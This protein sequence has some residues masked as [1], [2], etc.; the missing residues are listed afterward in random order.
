MRITLSLICL[1][2][3]PCASAAQTNN[4][5]WTNLN[6]LQAGEK[7]QVVDINAKKH[8]GIFTSVSDSAISINTSKGQESVQKDEVRTV[9]LAKG[10]HRLRNSLIG[11]G[12]GAG[13]GAGIGAASGD[14]KSSPLEITR[15][16]KAA[17]GSALGGL[18]GTLAGLLV[19]SGGSSAIYSASPK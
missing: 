19:P 14:S 11:L 6:G 3:I 9:K 12:V 13:V 15:G 2:A 1:L 18:G 4:A 5:S 16:M 10:S 7:I 17:A 8:S